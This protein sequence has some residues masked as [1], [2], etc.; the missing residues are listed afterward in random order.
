MRLKVFQVSAI[1]F[2]VFGCASLTETE[3]ADV[4]KL[5]PFGKVLG[6]PGIVVAAPHS[7]TDSG[8]NPTAR[9]IQEKTGA[10]AVYAHARMNY[11]GLGESRARISV[12]RKTEQSQFRT[13]T[14][15]PDGRVNRVLLVTHNRN[16]IVA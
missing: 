14:C 15:E 4:A 9:Q 8:S 5:V 16:T 13:S 12:N 6:R 10:G 7:V 3:K 1:A 11:D 2:F